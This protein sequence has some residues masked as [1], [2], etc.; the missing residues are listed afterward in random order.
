M[1]WFEKYYGYTATRVDVWINCNLK[2]NTATEAKRS[3]KG[4]RLKEQNNG[5]TRAPQIL[6]HTPVHFPSAAKG[7]A[8]NERAWTTAWIVRFSIGNLTFSISTRSVVKGLDTVR[9]ENWIN[10]NNWEI[11]SYRSSL[12]EIRGFDKCGS[13]KHCTAKF[14]PDS[15]Y[16]ELFLRAEL[17]MP[18]IVN[19]TRVSSQLLTCLGRIIYQILRKTDR[20]FQ[21]VYTL[22]QWNSYGHQISGHDHF[23]RLLKS[24]FFSRPREK[25]HMMEKCLSWY[26]VQRYP[27]MSQ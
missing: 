11:R 26:F 4:K 21:R 1:S 3:P 6:V 8:W 16:S 20:H 24:A 12:H 5:C 9:K 17:E 19:N 23:N 15:Q 13:G 18:H 25:W 2:K 14:W 10:F 22:V 7:T 27:M